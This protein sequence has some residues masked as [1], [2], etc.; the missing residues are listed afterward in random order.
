[1]PYPFSLKKRLCIW[2]SQEKDCF[3]PALNQLRLAQYRLKYPN[4]HI[5]FI[6]SGRCLNEVSKQRLLAFCE[7]LSLTPI[8]FDIEVRPLLSDFR[9][10]MLFELAKK[11]IK[12]NHEDGSGNMGAASDC[13]RMIAP[14]IG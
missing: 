9:D 5:H 10:K 12:L 7:K 1:M 13:T 2:F 6:Y 8:D 3:M 11:E 14:V 4:L